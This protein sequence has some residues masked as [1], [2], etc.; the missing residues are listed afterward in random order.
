MMSSLFSWYRTS[1]AGEGLSSV[2]LEA[3]I[4]LRLVLLPC[5]YLYSCYVVSWYE[6]NR[7]LQ[8]QLTVTVFIKLNVFINLNEWYKILL[9]SV[10]H[11][12]YAPT[13]EVNRR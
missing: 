8:A 3:E 2:H 12:V 4:L 13:E 5:V 6:Y 10:L 11:S 9:S 1:C 7:T